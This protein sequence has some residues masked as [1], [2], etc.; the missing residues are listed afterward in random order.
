MCE[1]MTISMMVIAAA[2]A[3]KTS[4]D[5][6]KAADI[7]R[8]N[9]IAQQKI[10]QE[11]LLKKRAELGDKNAMAALEREREHRVEQA[12][13]RTAYG[14][15][16][17]TTG[18]FQMDTLLQGLGFGTGLQQAADERS[19]R[20]EK[21]GV[22]MQLRASGVGFTNQIRTINSQ[23]PSGL[24]IGLGAAMAGANAGAGT[25][26]GQAAINKLF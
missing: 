1:P 3:V 25:P 12:R 26:G 2:M 23:D 11:A 7:A 21:A 20:A 6:K 15:K 9:A 8:K 19:D 22:D 18:N 5:Q 13:I 4:M 17:A 24:E 14:E 16:G 10:D